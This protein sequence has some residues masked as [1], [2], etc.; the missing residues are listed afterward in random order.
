MT[1][2]NLPPIQVYVRN[3][4]LFGQKTGHGE[5]T[6]GHLVGVRSIQN[7]AFQFQVLLGDG[8]L[9]TGLPAH[10]I[11]F[12]DNA[13]K[14][15]LNDCQ[16]WDSISSEIDVIQYDLLLYMPVSLKL[17]S[18]EIIKGEYLFTIDCVGKYDLSRHP[19]HWKMYHCIKSEEGNFH[20]APQYRLRFLDKAMC[21]DGKEKL[22]PYDYNEV[23]WTVGS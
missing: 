8:A 3:E 1:N 12:K 9:F 23:I 2:K 18:G 20:I 5:F 16:M 6:V 19:I 22:P 15:D 17:F 7:Q 4:F 10:A 21:V 13:V 14:R 11:S